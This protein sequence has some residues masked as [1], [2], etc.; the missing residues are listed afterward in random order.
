MKKILAIGSGPLLEKGVKKIGGH[1]LR[2]WHFVKPLLDDGHRVSLVTLPIPDRARPPEMFRE[3]SE[4]RKYEGLPYIAFLKEDPEYLYP[5]LSSEI[6]RFKPDCII[7]VNTH[8]SG[9]AAKA[10]AHTPLWADLNGWAMAEGQTR[11]R[12]DGSDKFLHHF[13]RDERD[14]AR[15]ADRFS[16]VTKNQKYALMG[17]LAALG[18][19]NRHTFDYPFAEVVENA[20]NPMFTQPAPSEYAAELK[21]DKIPRDA[22][23]VLWS[24]GFN[25]W[26]DVNLLYEA[27]ST[28]MEKD[29]RIY[30]VSTG[31][32]IDGH[33]EK[34][35]TDFHKL[36]AASPFRKRFFLLGWVEAEYLPGI[37]A[38]SDIGINVDA[39]NY[40]TLF[41]ARNRIT[42]MLA[43]GLPVVTTLGTEISHTI[44]KKDLGRAT[45]LGD[46]RAFAE[47]ILE[48]SSNKFLIREMSEKVKDY[49]LE[50]YSYEYTTK[51]VREWVQNPEPAPDNQAKI[52][53][54]PSRRDLLGVW[55]NGV[56]KPWALLRD[57]DVEP[58]IHARRDLN[59]IREKPLFK[60]YKQLKQGFKRKK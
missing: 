50:K 51:P 45:P 14:S 8:P 21:G 31:G 47:A 7:G 38:E 28:A 19:F 12:L 43:A 17:E 33:D 59:L 5:F 34:T 27:L 35:Y 37:Y 24:G 4:K 46:P 60:L 16:T 41:G 42:N 2:T 15:R 58:M 44:R 3:S 18:R 20:V 52:K 30:F 54:H 1:C 25:T 29:E 32:S 9:V 23:V 10:A 39:V 40:E 48:L 57:E 22:F 55:L 26:T 11:A 6:D 36:L 56:E 13:W 53:K 49:A